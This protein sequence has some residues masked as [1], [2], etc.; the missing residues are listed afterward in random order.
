[1]TTFR[2]ILILL[3]AAGS[4]SVAANAVSPRGLSWSRPLGRGVKAD[5]A[6]AG[7]VVV[8]L[9]DVAALLHR[10]TTLFVDA[11]SPEEFSGGH[12]PGAIRLG[13]LK[14]ARARDLAVVLY[15]ANEFCGAAF[16]Q[17]VELRKSLPNVAVFVDGYEAWSGAGGAVEPE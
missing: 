3:A 11:R 6:A 8:E 10:P 13:D 1:M 12:L 7:F 9:K 17:A 15:C 5:V 16:E 14:P 4:L 2:R